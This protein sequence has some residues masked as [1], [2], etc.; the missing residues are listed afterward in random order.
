MLR[1]VL[2]KQIVELAFWQTRTARQDA[3]FSCALKQSHFD[4]LVIEKR[5]VHLHKFRMN[6]LYLTFWHA[7]EASS[8]LRNWT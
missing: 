7:F 8:A 3:S 4:F 6:L 5:T 2:N 1:D